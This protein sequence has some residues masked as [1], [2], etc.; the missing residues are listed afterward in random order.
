MT[1]IV[2]AHPAIWGLLLAAGEAALGALL[3][4]GGRAAKFGWIGVASFHLLLM[5]FGFGFWLWSVPALTIVIPLLARDWPGL[6]KP[7]SRRA[8]VATGSAA[9]TD[10]VAGSVPTTARRVGQLMRALARHRGPMGL[11]EMS[12][13]SRRGPRMTGSL[14][15][16]VKRAPR[17]RPRH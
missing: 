5:L 1:D 8:A 12:K 15:H 7:T 13:D 14:R 3:L 6:G 2:M 10:G 17:S 9:A 11:P 16:G 4:V